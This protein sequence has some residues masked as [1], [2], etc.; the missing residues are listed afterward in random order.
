MHQK[1]YG[2]K[3]VMHIPAKV[4][5]FVT[6]PKPGPH[7]RHRSIP[8]SV[9][10]RDVLRQAE[11]AAEAKRIISRGLVSIDGGT[12]VD[13]KHPV[14]LM[15]VVEIPLTNEAYRV[16]PIHRRGLRMVEI[17]EE[18]KVFKLGKV[19]RKSLMKG[20]VNQITLHDGRSIRFKPGEAAS[21]RSGDTLKISLPDQ[22]VLDHLSLEEGVQGLIYEGPKQGLHGKLSKLTE[23]SAVTPGLATLSTEIGEVTTL[24]DYIFAVGGEEPWI[25][26]Q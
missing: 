19:V 23:S 18:E 21:I 15:D 9:V 16:L 24:R 25:T 3:R 26:L 10:V 1:R 12:V 11:T 13:H 14:G 7:P 22:R 17:P 6:R 20:G 4:N 2:A 5:V 8:L